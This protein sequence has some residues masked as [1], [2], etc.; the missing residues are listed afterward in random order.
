V[1]EAEPFCA[2]SGTVLCGKRNRSVREAEPFC[3]GLSTVC[4]Y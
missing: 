3:E 1:R 2:G 4:V